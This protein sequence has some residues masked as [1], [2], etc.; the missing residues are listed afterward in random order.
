MEGMERARKVEEE[1]IWWGRRTVVDETPT[2][3]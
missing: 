2:V 1:I 3:H